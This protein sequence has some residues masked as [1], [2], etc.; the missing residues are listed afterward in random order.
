MPPPAAGRSSSRPGHAVAAP[1]APSAAD[2]LAAAKARD[3]ARNVDFLRVLAGDKARLAADPSKDPMV[4]YV[5]FGGGG[6]ALGG[7]DASA[8]GGGGGVPAQTNVTGEKRRVIVGGEI[9]IA[10]GLSDTAD[11]RARR[12][13]AARARLTRAASSEGAAAAPALPASE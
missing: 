5:A 8:G 11:E 4:G 13:A 10:S 1:A 3:I 7:G 6:H 12:A 2:D 9:Q